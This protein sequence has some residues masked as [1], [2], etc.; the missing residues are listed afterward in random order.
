MADD[1]PQKLAVA[2]VGRQEA[3]ASL[4]EWGEE[5]VGCCLGVDEE[6]QRILVLIQLRSLLV[7]EGE[8]RASLAED[9]EVWTQKPG[10]AWV[11]RGT[12][13]EAGPHETG[14]S[15]VGEVCLAREEG[16]LLE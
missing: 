16:G 11:L 3:E 4:Q 15:G 5:K 12:T 1:L 9:Q 13:V 7:A 10:W 14:S 8:A 6:A 2:G